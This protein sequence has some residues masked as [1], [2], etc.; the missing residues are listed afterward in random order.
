MKNLKQN[1]VLIAGNVSFVDIK[2]STQKPG[3]YFGN[4]SIAYD[5]GYFDKNNNNLG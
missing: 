2:E 4:M 1:L 3:E 5:D